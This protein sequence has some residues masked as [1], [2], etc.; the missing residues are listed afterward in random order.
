MGGEGF[1]GLLATDFE[2]SSFFIDS[3]HFRNRN[4]LELVP[5]MIFTI[6][7]ML[8]EGSADCYEWEDQWTVAT[9]DGGMA[10]QVSRIGTMP[11]S[12]SCHT[13]L[14]LLKNVVL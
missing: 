1:L 5:G 13:S 2:N 6:E 10:A 9:S 14:P 11:Y 7:P 3:Q 8:V 12:D 4:Y